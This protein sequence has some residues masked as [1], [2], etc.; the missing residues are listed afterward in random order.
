M[1]EFL[2]R[3]RQQSALEE[4]ANS[5]SLRGPV[6]RTY[7]RSLRPAVTGAGCSGADTDA[8]ELWAARRI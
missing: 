4:F 7:A 8:Q 3:C 1:P 6:A 5:R 2:C